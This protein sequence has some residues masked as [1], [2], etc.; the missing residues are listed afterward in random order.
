MH[1]LPDLPQ[2]A[3]STHP[4]EWLDDFDGNDCGDQHHIGMSVIRVGVDMLKDIK[5]EERQDNGELEIQE[6]QDHCP[7]SLI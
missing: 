7:Q 2:A 1:A 6:V 4:D 5:G 3:L